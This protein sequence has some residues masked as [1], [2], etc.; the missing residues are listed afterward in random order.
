MSYEDLR[1]HGSESAVKA[2]GKLRQQGK[3]YESQSFLSIPFFFFWRANNG[4][5]GRRGHRVLE[6]GCIRLQLNWG[7]ITP[8]YVSVSINRTPLA[9]FRIGLRVNMSAAIQRGYRILAK[10]STYITLNSFK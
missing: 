4:C 10:Y 5:S 2:A 7:R 9:S 8:C 6:V 3:P 1:E